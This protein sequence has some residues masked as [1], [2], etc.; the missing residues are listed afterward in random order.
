MLSVRELCLERHFLPVFEPLSFDLAAG[1]LLVVTGPNGSG[2]TTLIRLLAG[3][4]E[5]SSGSMSK[6]VNGLQYVGHEAAVKAELSVRENLRFNARLAH[7][8]DKIKTALAALGLTDC[9]EQPGRTLSAGQRKRTAL[10]RL[11]LDDTPLWLLDEPYTNLDAGGFEVMDNLLDSHLAGGGA[12]VMATHGAHRPLPAGG[13]HIWQCTE[14][15]LTT[16]ALA[17]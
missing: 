2:K 4:I 11:L 6:A 10:A 7:G 16:P 5:P 3:L 15:E 8:G 12:C 1:E 9:A 13:E 14:I 17:A